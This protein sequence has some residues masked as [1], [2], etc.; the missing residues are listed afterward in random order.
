MEEKV[1]ISTCQQNPFLN[2]SVSKDSEIQPGSFSL[3]VREARK[4]PQIP[5]AYFTRRSLQRRGS[6]SQALIHVGT[7]FSFQQAALSAFPS[8]GS[9]LPVPQ[10]SAILGCLPL[11]LPAQSEE[12]RCYTIVLGAKC[13]RCDADP[14]KWQKVMPVKQRRCKLYHHWIREPCHPGPVGSKSLPKIR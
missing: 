8:Q 3:A 13:S 1:L 12:M 9:H 4:Q 11:S 5:D 2:T 6:S 7:A 10:G 14:A